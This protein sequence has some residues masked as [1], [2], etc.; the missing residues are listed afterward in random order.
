[1]ETEKSSGAVVFREAGRR[2]YLLLN[3]GKGYWGF[4]KGNVEE[5]ESEKDAARR[6]VEEE[7]GI[8]S[9]PFIKGFRDVVSYFFRRR[10]KTVHKIV[11][12]FLAHAENSQVTL[13][14]EHIGYVWLPYEDAIRNLT[15]KNTKELLE[16]AEEF[17]EKA[18]GK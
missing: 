6:E 1:M 2:E 13:S 16:K 11:V 5:G 3:Y 8:H 18:S 9:A 15:F 12:Y 14:Q 4:A 17:L 10:G 7:T